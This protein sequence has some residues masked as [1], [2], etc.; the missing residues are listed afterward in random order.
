MKAPLRTLMVALWVACV[1]GAV[2]IVFL[3]LASITWVAFVVSGV[4]GILV[5]VP[6]GLWTAKAIKR[7]DP[8]WPPE[9]T[10]FGAER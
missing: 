3:S 2:L 10:R 1:A 4:V 8:N 9:R 6:A 5:G 7:D